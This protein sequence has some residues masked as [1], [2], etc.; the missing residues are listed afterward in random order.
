V[1]PLKVALEDLR[2][3]TAQ[4]RARYRKL[5]RPIAEVRGLKYDKD[6]AVWLDA[7]GNEYNQ[8]GLP[9]YEDGNR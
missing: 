6:G 1:K 3:I 2:E 8:L 9:V 5:M 7:E 4:R